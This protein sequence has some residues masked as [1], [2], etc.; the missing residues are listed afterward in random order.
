VHRVQTLWYRLTQFQKS[1]SLTY[2][3][4]WHRKIE[5]KKAPSHFTAIKWIIVNYNAAVKFLSTFAP[6]AR[7]SWDRGHFDLYAVNVA[8]CSTA[9]VSGLLGNDPTLSGLVEG[10]ATRYSK[11]THT[12]AAH[13]TNTNWFEENHASTPNCVFAHPHGPLHSPSHSSLHSLAT[14]FHSFKYHI[15]SS[16]Q[17]LPTN[18]HLFGNSHLTGYHNLRSSWFSSVTPR[19]CSDSILNYATVASFHN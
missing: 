5:K 19:N 12:Y 6:K 8:D 10:K 17:L 14:P 13:K 3:T 2:W 15:L 7:F 9:T 16:A 4:S 11:Y 18:A 1:G